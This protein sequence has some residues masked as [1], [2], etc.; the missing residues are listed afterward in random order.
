MKVGALAYKK[1][2]NKGNEELQAVVLLFVVKIFK[3]DS[4]YY[5]VNR[6]KNIL[7]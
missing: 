6:H 7:F 5:I 4:C 3:E 2:A 1:A